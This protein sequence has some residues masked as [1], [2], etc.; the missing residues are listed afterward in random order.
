MRVSRTTIECL[1]TLDSP[2]RDNCKPKPKSV[3]ISSALEHLETVVDL[4]VMARDK[5]DT[6][7]SHKHAIN[8][9]TLR[10]EMQAGTAG[11]VASDVWSTFLKAW[12]IEQL[13]EEQ[14]QEDVDE[15]A[16]KEQQAEIRVVWN[17]LLYATKKWGETFPAP[18]TDLISWPI[19][20]DERERAAV[21]KAA[22]DHVLANPHLLAKDVSQEDKTEATS[23]LK[24][25][26]PISK[27]RIIS[28]AEAALRAAMSINRQDQAGRARS[29]SNAGSVDSEQS[30]DTSATRINDDP[31]D[32]L[33]DL[34]PAAATSSTALAGHNKRRRQKDADQD[35]EEE[36]AEVRVRKRPFGHTP[37]RD[38]ESGGQDLEALA[39][40]ET[41]AHGDRLARAR[42]GKRR[43]DPPPGFGVA[44]EDDQD[45]ENVALQAQ[46]GSA[47]PRGRSRVPRPATAAQ[48]GHSRYRSP[49]KTAKGDVSL[50]SIEEDEEEE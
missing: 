19:D 34:V 17:A 36:E 28:I 8:I 41:L 45:M 15:D 30:R 14:P 21:R 9:E 12:G 5:I 26:W 22:R 33:L 40:E 27:G 1:E 16:K 31:E 11:L 37:S 48:S 39:F 49:T 7:L 6:N 32:M 25:A 29:R 13:P 4:F 50:D 20:F 3:D 47:T 46:R 35:D 38:Q 24:D 43:A 10:M 2:F 44:G 18:P 42:A 23:A